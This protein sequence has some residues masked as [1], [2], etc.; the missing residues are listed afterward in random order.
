MFFHIR[1]LIITKT[2]NKVSLIFNLVL[3]KENGIFYNQNSGLV[4]WTLRVTDAGSRNEHA[5]PATTNTSRLQSIDKVATLR[6][7]NQ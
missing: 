4:I 5:T 2:D 7:P 1:S 6:L 3:V